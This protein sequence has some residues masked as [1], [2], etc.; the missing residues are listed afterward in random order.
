MKKLT[1]WPRLV[2][3]IGIMLFFTAASFSQGDQRAVEVLTTMQQEYEASIEDI[4]DYIMVTDHHTIY[5]KKAWDN[6]RPYFKSRTETEGFAGI[7]STSTTDESDFLTPE[8]FASMKERAHYEGMEEVEGQ[9]VHVLFIEE[10]EGLFEDEEHVEET[11][12]NMRIYV[13]SEL[14]VPRQINFEV[15]IMTEEGDIQMVSPSLI[16]RD[17]RDIEGMLIPYETVMVVS[18]FSDM[19][20]DAEREEA[21]KAL[22]E[23]ER[24][25]ADMPEQ[26]R[27]MVKRMMG[28]QME[29]LLK[30]LEEDRMEFTVNVE[31]VRVNTGMEDF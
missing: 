17:F 16:N 2:A 11:V 14:W 25:L 23:M 1:S 18:G 21:E 13:D 15:E 30:A 4:D 29:D 31:E 9:D 19:M 20:T 10:I 28:D 26:Q 3:F 22:E 27:E 12:Q 24:E 8:V 7:A 6:G 5:Y